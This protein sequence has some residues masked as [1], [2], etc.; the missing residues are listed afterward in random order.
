VAT[1]IVWHFKSVERREHL[2]SEE[3]NLSFVIGT[4]FHVQLAYG[5]ALYDPA[6]FQQTLFSVMVEFHVLKA[7]N[8]P[9]QYLDEDLIGL[10]EIAPLG[11]PEDL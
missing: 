7:V 9:W 5:G 11:E 3:F 4:E 8:D 6:C 2:S 1:G 10:V